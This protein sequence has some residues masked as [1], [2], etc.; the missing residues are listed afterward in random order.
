MSK[1]LAS[2]PVYRKERFTFNRETVSFSAFASDFGKNTDFM[3][4]LWGDAADVGFGILSPLTGKVVY[5]SLAKEVKDDGGI[6]F[7]EF[8]AVVDERSTLAG[9]KVTIFNT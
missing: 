9:L 3:G 4:R 1:I 2:C 7:W 8:E 6:L 5:F